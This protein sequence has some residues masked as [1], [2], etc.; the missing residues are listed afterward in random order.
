MPDHTAIATV[1]IL[2]LALALCAVPAA[3]TQAPHAEDA[4]DLI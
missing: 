3:G 2:G 4:A 1:M